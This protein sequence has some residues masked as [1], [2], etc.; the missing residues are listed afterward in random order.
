MVVVVVVVVVMVV[1]AVVAGHE[2]V[3]AVVVAP[4]LTFGVAFGWTC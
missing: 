2:T 3:G 4:G 1:V